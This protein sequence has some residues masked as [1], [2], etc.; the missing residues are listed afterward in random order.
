MFEQKI[1]KNI[2]EM[3]LL[4]CILTIFSL[5]NLNISLFIYVLKHDLVTK[6]AGL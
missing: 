3:V 5:L 2:E 6:M 1:A 4:N